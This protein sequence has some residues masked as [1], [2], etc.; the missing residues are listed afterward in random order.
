MLEYTD[1]SKD[2]VLVVSY[3]CSGV[4]KSI[5]YQRYSQLVGNYI[6]YYDDGSVKEKARYKSSKTNTDIN[7][8]MVSKKFKQ[9]EHFEKIKIPR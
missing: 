6:E 1:V 4:V 5:A 9:G 8:K 2:T 7:R 3:Y